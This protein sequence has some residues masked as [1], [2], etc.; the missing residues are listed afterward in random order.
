MED[1]TYKVY[2]IYEILSAAAEWAQNPED[3]GAIENFEN[4]KN[5]LIIKDY[6]PLKQKELC[7]GFKRQSVIQ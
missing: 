2:E 4:I 5:S 7:F 3:K 6:M 1:Q